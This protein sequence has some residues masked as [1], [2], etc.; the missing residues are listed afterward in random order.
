[1]KSID[2]QQTIVLLIG[3][4]EFPHDEKKNLE[5]I[6][7]IAVNLNRLKNLL[8]DP[9]I[10]GIPEKNIVVS[11]N[12]TKQEIEEHLYDLQEKTKSA[13]TNL[14]VYYSGHGFPHFFGEKMNVYL[15]TKYS[16]S[17]RIT[18]H[19]I[20]ISDFATFIKN[21]NS[22]RK[23]VI[24]DACYSGELLAEG[25][26]GDHDSHISVEIN[27]FQGTY[28]MTSVSKD[29]KARFPKENTNAPTYFTGELIEVLVN[30]LENQ[31]NFLSAKDIYL[32]V[33]TNL[34]KKNLPEPKASNF[35]QADDLLW[36][37]NVRF[38]KFA[39]ERGKIE[40]AIIKADTFIEKEDYETAKYI[41]EAQL[42]KTKEI[43]HSAYLVQQIQNK[44]DDCVYLPRYKERFELFYSKV[45]Q[46][47]E[48][49]LKQIKNEL[50]IKNSE[51][52]KFSIELSES[53]KKVEKSKHLGIETEQLKKEKT[54]IENLLTAE[55]QNL[56]QSKSEINN[57]TTKLKQIDAQLVD[58]KKQNADYKSE[59]SK[60]HSLKKELETALN[61][62][63]QKLA[64]AKAQIGQLEADLNGKTNFS[65]GI[66]EEIQFFVLEK[67]A[68]WNHE[69]WIL[70]YKK[71]T[72]Q[73]GMLDEKLIGS[74]LEIEKNTFNDKINLEK[75]IKKLNTEKETLLKELNLLKNPPKPIEPIAVKTQNQN[76]TEKIANLAFDMIFVKGGT[77]RMGT[78]D[79]DYAKPTHDVTVSDFY[80]GKHEVTNAEFA[81]FLNDY[82]SD[83]IKSGDFS[84]QLMIEEYKWGVKK[85]GNTWQA[86]SGYEKHPV[87]YVT[88]Y[89][90]NEYCNWLSKKTNK[91]YSLPSEA[92]WEYAA[93]GGNS[94][95]VETLHATSLQNA[96]GRTKYA[97]TNN[98]SE[99]GD[100]AWYS[101]NSESKTHEVG[102]RKPNQLG[103]YDM[104]G[105]VYE[106]CLDWYDENYYKKSQ[107]KDPVNAKKS[108]Y[109]VLRGGSWVYYIVNCRVANRL[110][111][112]PD[113]RDYYGGF[114]V[115]RF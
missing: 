100:Y 103:I 18:T 113:L 106:W 24:L 101:E 44:I 6:P 38:D 80:I 49:N 19:S 94:Q 9:D 12:E 104:S 108:D 114:R 17:Q 81:A 39:Q 31:N 33:K 47:K 16:N 70:F 88:W 72:K 96:A 63:K 35:D 14:I 50:V 102:T 75:T 41:L 98:E 109:T 112:Y 111:S 23:W 54:E 95:Y 76:Y 20:P 58:L 92:Q 77:F 67:E 62:E 10:M 1:M 27:N 11:L 30:G 99:L 2:H 110:G 22:E 29:N 82:G 3:A 61:A 97:G 21:C 34:A 8:T 46:Q 7:N 66:I 93:G 107:Q 83:K 65:L 84:G 13:K 32:S 71:I 25:M 51:L 5:P 91:K 86:Q 57:L 28:V 37:K 105:N 85:N 40:A 52:S 43:E 69:Q 55:K 79:F 42:I 36:A 56:N 64:Q 59:I 78:D 26:L 48:E 60:L 74:L 73:F 45:L 68:K 115:V 87:V 90:A 53:L 15:T 4:T 89:G